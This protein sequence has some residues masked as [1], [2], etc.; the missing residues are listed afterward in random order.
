M[1]LDRRAFLAA[2]PCLAAASRAL[3]DP[4]R[5]DWRARLLAAAEAQVGVTTIYDPAYVRLAFPGG[6]VPPERGVCTDVVI[7][8]YRSAFGT[9]LQALVNGDMRAA[10]A[11]YPRLWGMSRPDR[12]IDHRRVPNLETFFRRRGAEKPATQAGTDYRPGDLVT[13]RLPGNLPHIAIVTARRSEGGR[14]LVV[15]N[16]GGGAKIE[17][18]LF[19]YPIVGRFSFAP[20]A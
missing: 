8:A 5:D 14:P 20:T 19:A 2:L 9:D 7:R 4:G 11:S 10:F 12:N 3:A 15:H 6:D 1:T 17:D 18:T 16:I 13:Q